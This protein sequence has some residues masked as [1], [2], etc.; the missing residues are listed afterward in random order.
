MRGGRA[1]VSLAAPL[2]A[3]KAGGAGAGG[4][5]VDPADRVAPAG[6]TWS[7]KRQ[8]REIARGIGARQS[9][10][11]AGPDAT[12]A[13][14]GPSKAA[15]SGAVSLS[16]QRPF[17]DGMGEAEGRAGGGESGEA[18]FMTDLKRSG[19]GDGDGGGGGGEIESEGQGRETVLEDIG[20]MVRERQQRVQDLESYMNNL[21]LARDSEGHNLVDFGPGFPSLVDSMLDAALEKEAKAAAAE[22]G[23]SAGRVGTEEDDEDDE[24]GARH[25]LDIPDDVKLDPEVRRGFQRIIKLDR[26]LEEKTAMALRMAEA[27]DP[28]K[29]AARKAARVEAA[30]K[31]AQERIETERRRREQATRLAKVL[32]GGEADERV[33]R[34]LSSEHASGQGFSSL[35]EEEEAELAE[36]LERADDEEEG[37]GNPFDAGVGVFDGVAEGGGG[38]RMSEID[39]QLAKYAWEGGSGLEDSPKRKSLT[40]AKTHSPVSPLPPSPGMAFE[41]VDYLREYREMKALAQRA[42]EV[43]AALRACRTSEIVRASE[44][45]IDSLLDECRHRQAAWAGAEPREEREGGA[46]PAAA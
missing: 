27:L 46:Q 9:R 5:A 25:P 19:G 39:A 4:A 30:T 23:W 26:K 42:E 38:R 3:A 44:E 16:G 45:Q 37:D 24:E 8:A 12:A 13:R 40:P 22:G 29:A 41:G 43:D 18:T 20:G 21:S 15:L 7:G 34:M 33:K 14:P 32:A 36:F 1:V 10:G 31:R 28:E 2:K 11:L 35:T 17:E 6:S